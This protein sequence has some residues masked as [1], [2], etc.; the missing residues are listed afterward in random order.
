MKQSEKILISVLAIVCIIAGYLALFEEEATTAKVQQVAAQFESFAQALEAK[1]NKQALSPAEQYTLEKMV[2]EAPPSPFYASTDSFYFEEDEESP[3]ETTD[4]LY[5]GY[6][7]FGDRVFAIIN[8]IEYAVGD[9]IV[10]NGMRVVSINRESVSLERV[11]PNTGRISSRRIP[12]V[13]DDTEQITL[14]RATQ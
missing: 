8:N 14:R 7:R 10:D 2:E 13:E 12:L 4:V 3:V 5:S 1:I 11:D 6:L 9:T